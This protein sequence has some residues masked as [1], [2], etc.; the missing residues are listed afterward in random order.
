MIRGI[1]SP[2]NA[3]QLCLTLKVLLG[4]PLRQA[5]G[6]VASLL[7]LSGLDWSVPFVGRQR[8]F[9]ARGRPPL[10]RRARLS[11]DLAT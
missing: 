4:L 6:F 10:A 9:P 8:G 2:T 3:I 5:N 11:R 1:N 7:E